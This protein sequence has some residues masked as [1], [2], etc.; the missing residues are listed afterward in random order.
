MVY[1]TKMDKNM[2]AE[3]NICCQLEYRLMGSK[4]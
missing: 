1:Y 2:D 4:V 3:R